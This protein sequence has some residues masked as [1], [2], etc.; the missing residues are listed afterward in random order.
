MQTSDESIYALGD[1]AELPNG[2]LM[3]LFYRY[4]IR[5]YGWQDFLPVRK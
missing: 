2:K 3:L 4:A 1:V 5:P